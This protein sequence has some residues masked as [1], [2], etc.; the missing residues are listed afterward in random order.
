MNENPF[1]DKHIHKNRR[2]ERYIEIQMSSVL[3]RCAFIVL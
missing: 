1:L 2:G 3:D